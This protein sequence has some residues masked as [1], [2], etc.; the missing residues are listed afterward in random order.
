MQIHVYCK[1]VDNWGDAGFCW[2][3]CRQLAQHH[4]VGSVTLF[5]EGLDTLSV[6]GITQSLARNHQVTL[7]DWPSPHSVPDELPELL[8]A[9]FGCD[10]PQQ[11]RQ[12]VSAQANSTQGQQC[13]W[14]NLEY[15]S[16]EPWIES[17]HWQ[18]SLKPDGALE[19]FYMPGFTPKTGGILG[20]ADNHEQVKIADLLKKIQ[21]PAKSPDERWAS[22][23]CYPEAPTE[24]LTLL[25]SSWTMLI[26]NSV[27]FTAPKT[28]QTSCKFHQLPVLSQPEYDALL[29]YCDVNF[30][31]G[32]ESWVRAQ[33]AGKPF[34]W[35]PYRQ[36]ENVHLTKLNA[37]ITLVESQVGQLPLWAQAMQ[38][39]N[40]QVFPTQ[41]PAT[42]DKLS[43]WLTLSEQ[44]PNQVGIGFA[45]WQQYLQAQTTLIERLLQ[46]KQAWN[47]TGL[48]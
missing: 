34:I 22:L 8:I 17:H 19:M 4:K 26:A 38:Q 13:V 16:A 29:A 5:V 37:F 1:V 21:L 18:R 39:W 43:A 47:S 40:T 14:I 45:Q 23:F 28:S 20:P 15:L 33:W 6:M 2:R 41:M 32:E 12:S 30:V 25:G 7:S 35:Q 48:S 31:R 24:S 42:G 46:A 11:V 9:S 36:A 27:E 10:L 44:N 3:L